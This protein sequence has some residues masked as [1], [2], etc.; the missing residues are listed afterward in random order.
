MANVS[1]ILQR[2]GSKVYA[3]GPGASVLEAATKM[4]DDKVGALVVCDGFRV[5]G[6][7]TERD[8]LR[9]VVAKRHDPAK[10]KVAQVMTEKVI[11]CQPGTHV[12]EVRN[13]FMSRRIR[14]MPVVAEDDAIMGL[15]SI[16]DLNAWDLDGQEVTIHYLREYLYGAA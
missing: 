2:K 16:G 11:C 7:V 8:M 6:I 1:D 5:V 10:L 12:D 15:I 9:R 3:I 14:H 13:I 4:N